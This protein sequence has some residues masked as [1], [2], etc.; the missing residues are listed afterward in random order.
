MKIYGIG[1]QRCPRSHNR[2]QASPSQTEP[3]ELSVPSHAI[4]EH[5]KN[6]YSY[7]QQP[8]CEHR[9]MEICHPRC[10]RILAQIPW[11]ICAES[12]YHSDPQNTEPDCKG[13]PIVTRVPRP[14]YVPNG[15]RFTQCRCCSH[16]L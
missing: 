6:L 7:D 2:H 11:K 12:D 3:A 14:A 13:S 9:P 10:R 4:L 1:R 8:A 16:A 5:E 15:P